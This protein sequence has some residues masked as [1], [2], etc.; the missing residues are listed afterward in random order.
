MT[1]VPF[2]EP[3][4]YASPPCQRHELDPTYGG[5]E[6]AAGP[7]QNLEQMSTAM[8]DLN[9]DE[10]VFFDEHEPQY[11]EFL[12][13]KEKCVSGQPLQRTWHHFTS[14]DSKFFAGIWEAEPGC[15]EVNYTENEFCR[16]LA[17]RSILRDANGQERVL[18]PGDNFTIPCGFRGQWEVLETT[19]KIYV[20]YEP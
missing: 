17:G 5:D 10:L 20:I 7:S 19:R 14:A 15:W 6:P 1:N 4:G 3:Q 8:N 16:I 12:T 11:E 13:A 18:Q 2:E 9:L